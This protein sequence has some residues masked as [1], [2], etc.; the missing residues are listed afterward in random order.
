MQEGKTFSFTL[1][2]R[3]PEQPARFSLEGANEYGIQ[4]DSLG[5]FNWTPSFDLVDRLTKQKEI[6]VIFQAE[7][8]DNKR[9]RQPVNFLARHQEDLSGLQRGLITSLLIF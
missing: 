4:F 7:L 1:S 8:K 3:D 5:N 9:L 2:V 6:G